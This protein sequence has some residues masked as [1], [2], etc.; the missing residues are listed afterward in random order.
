VLGLGVTARVELRSHGL[1]DLDRST[2]V[3]LGDL[4]DTGGIVTKVR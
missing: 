2:I 3:N 1:R 4:D